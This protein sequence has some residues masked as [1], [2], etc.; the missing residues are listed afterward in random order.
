MHTFLPIA[1]IFLILFM[2][3]CLHLEKLHTH[4]YISKIK[5]KLQN[6]DEA[7]VW[8]KFER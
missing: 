5:P 3:C 8:P 1:Y 2:D 4:N 7:C 6:S